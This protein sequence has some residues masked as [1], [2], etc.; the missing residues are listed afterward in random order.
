MDRPYP[1]NLPVVPSCLGC[2]SMTSADE[3]YVAA[4]L[5]V[6]ACES[7]DLAELERRQIAKSLNRNVSLLER[8]RS[9]AT[10]GSGGLTLQ[11]EQ[12]RFER[13]FGKIARGLWRFDGGEPTGLL[14][15][16]VRYSQYRQMTKPEVDAFCRLT[17]SLLPEVGSRMLSR[18]VE[19]NRMWNSWQCLQEFRFSYAIETSGPVSR[20]KMIARGVLCIEVALEDAATLT[21]G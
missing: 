12:D 4:A 3:E 19:D 5:E 15:D 7:A 16:K 10:L 17:P 20:V 1:E 6:I 8:L 14:N 9:A 21:P 18:L 13:V 2:N 11:L